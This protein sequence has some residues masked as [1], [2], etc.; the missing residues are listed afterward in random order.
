METFRAQST[1]IPRL[2]PI[3]DDNLTNSFSGDRGEIIQFLVQALEES[4]DRLA[5]WM[6]AA[7]NKQIIG[8][9]IAFNSVIRP[10]ARHVLIAH[11][12][13]KGGNSVTEELLKVAKD[14]ALECGADK[15][16][17]AT[18][19]PEH[20]VIYGFKVCDETLMEIDCG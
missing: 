6:I 5:V 17:M 3:K 13:S 2:L 7:D 20:F 9:L 16:Q 11:A 14:W 1:D 4:S 15:I 8:Y 10:V 19:H 12:Y 18:R